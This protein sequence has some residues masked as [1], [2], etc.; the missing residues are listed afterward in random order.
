M[1]TNLLSAPLKWHGGKTYLAR[2]ILSLM[3]RHVHYVEPFA[4][5]LAVLLARDPDD[6]RLWLAPHQGVSEVV[7][8]LDGRLVNFWRVLQA[9]D[10]FARF[11]RQVQA[12][13]IS[14]AE[15]KQAHG[16]R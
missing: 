6:P 5:G 16:H 3:P 10:F 15:W 2:W 14:R 9:D 13:P 11:A 7:N 12:V 1:S 4:G 8:D